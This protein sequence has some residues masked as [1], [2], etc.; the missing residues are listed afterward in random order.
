MLRKGL[1]FTLL[2]VQVALLQL[3][4]VAT[5]AIPKVLNSTMQTRNNAITKE[6][7]GALSGVLMLYKYERGNVSLATDFPQLVPY[8]KLHRNYVDSIN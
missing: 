7:M 2:E 4:T 6:T 3:G 1:G 8:L 5:F